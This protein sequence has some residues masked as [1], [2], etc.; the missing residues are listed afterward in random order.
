M[1]RGIADRLDPV[2]AAWLAPVELRGVRLRFD[3]DRTPRRGVGVTTRP[4]LV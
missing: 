4:D 3:C 2:E 1:P